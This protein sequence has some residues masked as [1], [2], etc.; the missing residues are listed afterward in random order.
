MANSQ[1]D[2]GLYLKGQIYEA[3]SDIQNIRTAISAYKELVSDF[4]TSPF[5]QLAKNRQTYLNRFYFDIR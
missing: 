4:P 2:S 5:W 3:K 1:I